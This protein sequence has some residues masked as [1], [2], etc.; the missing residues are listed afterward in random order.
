MK[1]LKA[2]L[3]GSIVALAA[4]SDPVIPRGPVP[5][6]IDIEPDLLLLMLGDSAQLTAVARSAT[7]EIIPNV[8]FT[9]NVVTPFEHLRIT[10][11]GKVIAA[12]GGYGTDS[13]RVTA[14]AGNVSATSTVHVCA[15]PGLS[16][17]PT[18]LSIRPR[19]GFYGEGV[20]DGK[21][22][23]H[24]GGL[25]YGTSPQDFVVA[26]KIGT[27]WSS[28]LG[29]VGT[30][31]LHLP[32]GLYFRTAIKLVQQWD[33]P[34][35]PS[36]VQ[37]TEEVFEP[38]SPLASNVLLVRYTFRN[39]TE[40]RIENF[41]AGLWLDLDMNYSETFSK[42]DFARFNPALGSAE[43]FESTFETVGVAGVDAPITSFQVVPH[44][45]VVPTSA[46]HFQ[47]LMGIQTGDVGPYDVLSIVGFGPFDIPVGGSKTLTIVLGAGRTRAEFDQSISAGR[48]GALQFPQ[49]P[50]PISP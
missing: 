19:F 41:R 18:G 39:A 13:V 35:P 8:S 29:P 5:A 28:D 23:L 38:N 22:V 30:C 33:D 3:A 9:W 49:L 17:W 46:D 4:C 34:I 27:W 36:P 12:S 6:T 2:V 25:I 47:L 44:H 32:E 16:P 48:A 11:S 40:Q 10:A 45:T 37:T 42:D 14:T 43:T 24:G 26:S 15:D 7:G 31:V 21:E 20:F 1:M 50:K